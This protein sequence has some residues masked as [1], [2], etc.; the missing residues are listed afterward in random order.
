MQNFVLQKNNSYLSCLHFGQLYQSSIPTSRYLASPL[1]YSSHSVHKVHNLH[2]PGRKLGRLGHLGLL[3]PNCP[4]FPGPSF[5][6]SPMVKLEN[7]DLSDEIV[8]LFL[9]PNYRISPMH[10]KKTR[11]RWNSKTRTSRTKKSKFPVCPNCCIPS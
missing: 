6:F 2:Q 7:S 9:R 10:Q 1:I 5:P 4:S 3:G 11:T 8:R